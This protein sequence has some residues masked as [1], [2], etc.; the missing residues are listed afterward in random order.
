M[1]TLSVFY[2]LSVDRI[3]LWS[4]LSQIF[5]VIMCFGGRELRENVHSGWKCVTVTTVDFNGTQETS[6][7]TFE[8][9]NLM[10]IRK[11]FNT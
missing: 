10:Q 3:R 4:G 11:A 8:D 9:E 6:D 5:I 1:L 2:L 7:F